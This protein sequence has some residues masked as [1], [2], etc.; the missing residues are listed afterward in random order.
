MRKT[1]SEDKLAIL[2]IST[3]KGE[4]SLVKK[5]AEQQKMNY[6]ILV[7][8]GRLPR[9]YNQITAIPT[10]FFIDPKGNIKF[11]TIGTLNLA[12]TKKILEAQ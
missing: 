4:T 9:P 11:A 2:G 12:D 3:E 6:T 7:D 5:F 8:E 10:T 1:T